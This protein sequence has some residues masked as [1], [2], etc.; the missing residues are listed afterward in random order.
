[1]TWGLED[2]PDVELN[3]AVAAGRD[4]QEF[5]ARRNATALARRQAEA[6]AR[7]FDHE[8]AGR[9]RQAPPARDAAEWEWDDLGPSGPDR[10]FPEGSAVLVRYPAEERRTA[11]DR[12]SWPWL[13]GTIE[14]QCGPDEWLVTV[15]DRRLAQLEDGRPAPEGTPDSELLFPQC[16]RD[17]S[18]LREAG[19]E[20]QVA[21]LA[22]SP[23]NSRQ[24][25]HEMEAGE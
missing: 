15:E 25:E 14:Q 9:V 3:R 18:E 10:Q 8:A 20:P 13:H 23:P 21:N 17:A 5:M 22:T 4:P 2:V 24:P 7:L 11:S 6:E 16:F 12:E 19:P 1:M